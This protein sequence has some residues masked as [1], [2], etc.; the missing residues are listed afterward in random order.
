MVSLWRAWEGSWGPGSA[1]VEVGELWRRREAEGG[2]REGAVTATLVRSQQE[3][4]ILFVGGPVSLLSV[5]W[6]R[7][8][9]PC[10][11]P[12]SPWTISGTAKP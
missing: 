7:S 4:R 1:V 6:D 12:L 3:A 5:Y 8:S 11:P 9:T 2:R 10:L